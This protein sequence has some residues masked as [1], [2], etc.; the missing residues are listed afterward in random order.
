MRVTADAPAIV[1]FRDDLRLADQPALHAAAESGRP[2]ICIYILDDGTDG[3]RPP[4]G[5]SRWWLHHSLTALAE[6][7]AR[8]G[9]R[10]DVL[11]GRPLV[12][13]RQ[14]ASASSAASVFWTRRYAPAEREA[15][16]AIKAAL[17]A[18]GVEV[19]SF[20][21]QLLF[22]PWTVKGKSGDFLKVFTPFWR[23]ALNGPPPALP[24][25]APKSLKTA[26]WPAKGPARVDI[27]DL[28]LLPSK[29]DW[30]GGLR[31]AWTPGEA[32][33]RQRFDY[34]LDSGLRRYAS[35]RDR[36]DVEATSRLSPHL[37]FGEISPRQIFHAVRHLS[38][39]DGATGRDAEKFLSE[40][41][42]REFSYNLLF[43]APD[44][45]RRNFQTRFDAF[46]WGE[47]SAKLLDAWRRGRTGYPIVDAGMRELWITGF[48]HNRVRMIAASFLIKHL[49]IDWRTGEEWFW[50]TLCDADP[51]NNPAGWQWVAGSGA[52]A[53]P[54][55]RVF[56]PILQGEKFDP[57]GA[58][59]R[60]YVPELAK[61]PTK[62]I[63]K[64]WIAPPDVRKAA[65]LASSKT[66]P[67]PIVDHDTA[68]Q[69]ALAAFASLRET[70]TTESDAR[71]HSRV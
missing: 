12:L 7:F 24:L 25:P 29:P 31:A 54:Y 13:L 39:A 42:W 65:G 40:V 28:G 52:D 20:N 48:M 35:D 57:D 53:A 44:L 27:G 38:E 5:A 68:R 30:A 14:L 22:E 69:R 63:H 49:M 46:P 41:G 50:D 16:A 66:Y 21:G 8:I 58:Y 10:L 45:T 18:D 67:S 34:F 59:V 33:A 15:D 26:K 1:W 37:R 71:S 62:W 32:G 3:V 17:Q 2:L 43:H 60:T 55:F 23:A 61:L 4:G 51:A 56:N 70:S 11:R 47:P 6:S 9:G 19:R 64:P 36:P